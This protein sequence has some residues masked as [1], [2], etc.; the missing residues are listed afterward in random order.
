MNNFGSGGG[1]YQGGSNYQG[2]Y[3]KKFDGNKPYPPKD[4]VK[5]SNIEREVAN[6]KTKIYNMEQYFGQERPGFHFDA[7]HIWFLDGSNE[8]F[9][10]VSVK[11]YTFEAKDSKGQ[12]VVIMKSAIKY[13]R[14]QQ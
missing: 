3:K 6:L 12:T 13:Y 14:P 11:K 1:N 4:R 9:T 8:Q 10:D 2:G 5:L 7:L